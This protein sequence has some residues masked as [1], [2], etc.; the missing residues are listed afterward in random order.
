MIVRVDSSTSSVTRTY[1]ENLVRALENNLADVDIPSKG[2]A[3]S[4]SS[5]KASGSSKGRAGR[6]KVG[7]SRG[8]GSSR[9]AEEAT[10]WSCEHCTYANTTATSSTVCVICHYPRS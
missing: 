4:S 8:G 5:S 7:S 6:A 1:F 2:V 9:G 3:K 10:H